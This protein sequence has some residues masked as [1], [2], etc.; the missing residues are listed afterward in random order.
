MSFCLC[1]VSS[2]SGSRIYSHSL[3]RYGCVVPV[4]VSVRGASALLCVDTLL[5]RSPVAS[6]GATA[7]E[8]PEDVLSEL[9]FCVA[10]SESTS[11]YGSLSFLYGETSF[12]VWYR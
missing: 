9:M 10:G 8:V 7:E 2:G 1:L 5:D 11:S 6:G 12:A 4:D 3:V